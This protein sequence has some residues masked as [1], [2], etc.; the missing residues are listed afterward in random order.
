[1]ADANIKKLKISQSDMPPINSVDEGYNLRYRIISED[2]NRLSHWSP[3]YL[4]EPQYTFV[5]GNIQFGSGAQISNFVWDPVTILK[6]KTSVSNITNKQLT[7]DLATLTTSAA[8]YMSVADWVTV[9][10][11]DAT[12]N[13][14]YKINAVTTTTFSY[15]KDSGNVAST[16]V[17][18]SGTYKTNSLVG[19]AT[20]YDIWLRW[21]RNDGGDWIYKERIQT[22]SV[23]YPHA[24]FY[25]INGVVQPSAPNRLSIEIYLTGSPIA[26]SDGAAGTPFL[27]V[28][29]LLNETI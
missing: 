18:P 27:K 2:R 25:T 24:S 14:T 28:Y 9:E 29:R 13:G 23:S 3:I 26:R 19:N 20:G 22:T 21:D 10:G 11:V 12:F 8:H 16:P 4:I 15:Y 1:M 7:S 17:S 5:P 6:N